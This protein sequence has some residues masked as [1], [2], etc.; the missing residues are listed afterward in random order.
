MFWVLLLFF[1][2]NWLD[3]HLL[4]QFVIKDFISWKE[5]PP[6]LCASLLDCASSIMMLPLDDESLWMKISQFWKKREPELTEIIEKHFSFRIPVKVVFIW[7]WVIMER[8][9]GGELT[10]NT[11][12]CSLIASR[13]FYSPHFS[14]PRSFICM[15]NMRRGVRS[16]F[17][18]I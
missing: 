11:L 3:M 6:A 7:S 2:R 15:L 1:Y 5:I 17:L 8:I 12:M 16:R 9:L 10:S 4:L 13:L 14:D 18:H